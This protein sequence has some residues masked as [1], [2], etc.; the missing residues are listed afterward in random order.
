MY[1]KKWEKEMSDRPEGDD[2]THACN[3]FKVSGFNVSNN[4]LQAGQNNFAHFLYQLT[5]IMN[6]T[7]EE[8]VVY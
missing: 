5:T 1:T 2:L 4:H 7:T 6:H 3:C 8:L